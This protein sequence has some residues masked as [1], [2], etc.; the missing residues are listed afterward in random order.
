MPQGN[1]ADNVAK[2]VGKQ[3]RRYRDLAGMSAQ[4]MADALA[5]LGMPI[6]RSVLAG[7]ENGRRKTV[8]VAEVIAFGKVLGIAPLAL[9]YP[10]DEDDPIEILPGQL[11]TP[12]AASK[13]FVGDTPFPDEAEGLTEAQLWAWGG[14]ATALSLVRKHDRDVQA[15][16][17]F[18]ASARKLVSA[19]PFS[20][21][22]RASVQDLS[23]KAV[24]AVRRVRDELRARG[25]TPPPLPAEF[26]EIDGPAG[27]HIGPI[28]PALRLDKVA[29][30]EEAEAMYEQLTQGMNAIRG[31]VVQIDHF[32]SKG[33]ESKA[34]DA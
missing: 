31:L 6:E 9:I 4:K 13:W 1:W 33:S 26:M 19:A 23:T 12:L 17:T 7:L 10:V 22:A 20:D 5:E 3:V 29:S 11:S 18:L 16:L 15:V 34:A 28:P 32:T 14:D 21:E 24:Q 27:A 30:A 2:T 8:S 25:V